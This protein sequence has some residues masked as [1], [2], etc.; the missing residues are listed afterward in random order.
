MHWDIKLKSISNSIFIIKI[1]ILELYLKFIF[2]LRLFRYNFYLFFII[3]K[4]ANYCTEL[5]LFERFR[6][7]LKILPTDYHSLT[8]VASQATILRFYLHL[9]VRFFG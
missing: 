5:P 4:L 9:L 8:L 6:I 3:T 1:I 7:L 2:L